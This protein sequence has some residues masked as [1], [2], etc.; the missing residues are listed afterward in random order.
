MSVID[1][2]MG[3]PMVN[4]GGSTPASLALQSTWREVAES[5]H[6]MLEGISFQDLVDRARGQDQNMY[7]I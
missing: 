2:R 6:D 5:L 3:P 7:Y 1:G 4:A